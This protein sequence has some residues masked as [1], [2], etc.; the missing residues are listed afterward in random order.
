MTFPTIV[1]V[2]IG[3]D[4]GATA[5]L[6]FTFSTTVTTVSRSWEIKVTQIECS[7]L[8]RPYDAGCLQY[9]TGTTGRLT[10][11]NFA[12]SSSSDYGHLPSQKYAKFPFP[13]IRP[14]QYVSFLYHFQPKHLHQARIW[15][16]L[17]NLQRL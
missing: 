5:K 2:D 15:V 9:F 7:S 17:Y 11:F 3:M 8:A 10:S 6:E 4:T 13:H 1:Y 16:L 12:Q 14:S